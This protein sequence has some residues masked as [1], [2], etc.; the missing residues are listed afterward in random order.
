MAVERLFNK[1]FASKFFKRRYK[2]NRRQTVISNLS[3]R[4]FGAIDRSI[5]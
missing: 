1:N 4:S 2:K 5:S 3:L